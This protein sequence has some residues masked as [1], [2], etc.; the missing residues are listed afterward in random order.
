MIMFLLEVVPPNSG[1]ARLLKYGSRK[2]SRIPQGGN[3]KKENTPEWI[4]TAIAIVKRESPKKEPEPG[5]N[6]IPESSNGNHQHDYS[7]EMCSTGSQQHCTR[8]LDSFA[9]LALY[10]KTLNIS[11]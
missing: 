1:T 4:N 3:K 8:L 9:L 11:Y 10:A 7:E 2:S 6:N 5:V